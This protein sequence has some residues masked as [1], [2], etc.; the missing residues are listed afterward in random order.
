[1][2]DVAVLL[3]DVVVVEG[4]TLVAGPV[5]EVSGRA[6]VLVV[7]ATRAGATVVVGSGGL[8]TGVARTWG[9]SVVVVVGA[10]RITRSGAGRGRGRT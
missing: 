5:V 8:V 1:V 9:R 10:T 6:V 3:G 2:V 7:G 4:A